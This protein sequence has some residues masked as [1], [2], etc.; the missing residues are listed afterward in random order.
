MRQKVVAVRACLFGGCLFSAGIA[1]HARPTTYVLA[2]PDT[3]AAPSSGDLSFDGPYLAD[4]RANVDDP[5]VFSHLGLVQRPVTTQTFS[6]LD[7]SAIADADGIIAPWWQDSDVSAYE[8]NVAAE[9]F[10]NGGDLFLFQDTSYVDP[11]GAY[12]GIPTQGFANSYTFNGNA[13][14]FDGPFGTTTTVRMGGTYGYLDTAD[15]VARGGQVLAVNGDGKP[16]VAFW[17][18]GWYSPGAGRMIIVTDIDTIT[19]A[20]CCFQ[21]DY[22]VFNDNAKFALNLVAGMIAEK[23]Q[24]NPADIDGNGVLNL[25]DI[26][27]FA[28]HFNDG[29]P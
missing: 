16:V 12:L 22:G 25:D 10:W 19:S 13:F 20:G 24:C 3:V 29:C 21:A 7:A 2:G 4:F 6:Y 5:S 17:D 18:R 26:I 23:E 11:I 28:D 15:V 9:H 14:P 1:A 8:A 27:L